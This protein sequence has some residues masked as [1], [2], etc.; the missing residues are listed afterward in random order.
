MQHCKQLHSVCN[1]ID[2][3][4]S[5]F[6]S[7]V[8]ADRDVDSIWLES[9]L[10]IVEWRLAELYFKLRCVSRA[11]RGVNRFGLRLLHIYQSLVRGDFIKIS[12][13]LQFSFSFLFV[14]KVL[15]SAERPK[16]ARNCWKLICKAINLNAL[17]KWLERT[18]SIS[19]ELS[20]RFSRI[21]LW[22]LWS[23]IYLIILFLLSMVRFA[24]QA[25]INLLRAPAFA[26]RKGKC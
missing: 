11:T 26:F 14:N 16:L 17:L 25:V 7:F 1:L 24:S 3:G 23:L 5:D 2:L 13:E 19:F 22:K 9:E 6:H 20:A 4:W 15:K 18:I 21:L 10:G 12:R 8:S